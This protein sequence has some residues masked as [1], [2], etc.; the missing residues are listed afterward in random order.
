MM[1]EVRRI[2]I[3]S[4]FSKFPAGRYRTDGEHSG[5]VFRD[6]FLCPALK[7]SRKVELRLDGAMGYGS[8]FLDEAFGGL[9]RVHQLNPSELHKRLI[10]VTERK[11][12]EKEIWSY[13][14]QSNN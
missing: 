4:D 1:E 8:S 14:D 7:S 3:A 9:V 12:I 6:D 5:E 13:I 11:S 2:N 10:L